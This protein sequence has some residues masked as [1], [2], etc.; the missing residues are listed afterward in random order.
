[1]QVGITASLE[2]TPW[3]LNKRPCENGGGANSIKRR[4]EIKTDGVP[5]SLPPPP[6]PESVPAD[7]TRKDRDHVTTG[8]MDSL[9]S[10]VDILEITCPRV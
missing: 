3:K 6:F 7:V 4:T 2:E 10:V 9:M 8:T 5:P 1:M